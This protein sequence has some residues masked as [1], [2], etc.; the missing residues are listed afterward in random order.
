MKKIALGQLNI[1]YGNF[2]RNVISAEKMIQSAV[3]EKCDLILLPELW[4]SGFD[5]HHLED[6]ANNNIE[7][8]THLQS[9]SDRSSITICGSF[10]EKQD[11]H[12]Y[13]SFVTIQ[14]H[15]PIIRYHKIHL[16]QLMHEEKYFTPGIASFPFSSTLGKA[17]MSICFDLRFPEQF[18]DLSA[19]GVEVYL[20]VA[21]WPL[22]RINHW[23]VLLQAR[24]IE[25]QAFMIA[26]NS[27]GKS[28]KD[29]YG[30]HSM[31]IAPDGE[32]LL[33]ASPNEENL[34]ITE[35]DESST[36]SLREKFVI[37]R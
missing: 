10:I 32:I 15:Q 1:E 2:Q 17:G 26:V 11:S 3:T 24:A 28:G 22:V 5:L 18:R 16:F 29:L 6:H 9:I 27:V 13:N 35:I 34:F 31:V 4:S 7:V 33:N 20:M 8:I 23:Q 36:R 12:F 30:G 25:N 14:P 37:N 19:Q 21:H